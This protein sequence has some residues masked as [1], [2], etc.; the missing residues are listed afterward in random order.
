[1][2]ANT[3]T[4]IETFWSLL[5]EILNSVLFLIIGVEVVAL[6]VTGDTVLAVALAIPVVLA[7]R[8]VS[9]AWPITLLGLRRTFTPGAIPVLSWGG[10]RCAGSRWRSRC[11][12]RHRRSGTCCSP[13]LMAS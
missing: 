2:S 6:S 10:L 7:A 11:R 8:F 3:R 1:M 4:H 13:R 5:D 9:V 12:C